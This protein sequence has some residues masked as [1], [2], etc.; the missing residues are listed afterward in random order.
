MKNFVK[1]NK[2]VFIANLIVLGFIVFT[3]FAQFGIHIKVY[4]GV[5]LIP[6]E[7]QYVQSSRNM[8]GQGSIYTYELYVRLKYKGN[9]KEPFWLPAS[10]VFGIASDDDV[11]D[12]V[13]DGNVIKRNVFINTKSHKVIGVT[14]H[15]RSVLSLY[16]YNSKMLR[17]GIP[18]LIFG[19][20]LVGLIITAARRNPKV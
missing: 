8:R 19:D 3:L 1:K 11:K 16:F 7:T 18:I 13:K 2:E 10:S 20:I 4:T 12:M 9:T 6:T 15:G 17:Y 5:D 14:K